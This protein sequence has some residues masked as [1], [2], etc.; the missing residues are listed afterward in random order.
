MLRTSSESSRQGVESE[1]PAVC[2]RRTNFAQ[3]APDIGPQPSR[4][5]PSRLAVGSRRMRSKEKSELTP[6][7]RHVGQHPTGLLAEK[8]RGSKDPTVKSHSGQA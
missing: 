6:V 1:K 7:P 8:S 4:A 3:L 2:E 5:V